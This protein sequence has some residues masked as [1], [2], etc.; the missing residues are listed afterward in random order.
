M[1]RYKQYYLYVKKNIKFIYA[2]LAIYFFSAIWGFFFPSFFK[3][4]IDNFITQILEITQNMN[5][6]QIFLFIL[7]NNIKTAFFAILFGAAFGIFPIF[8][9]FFNGYVLGYISSSVAK[10]SG[11]AQ[12]WKLLPHGVFELVAVFLSFSLGIKLGL[13]L[14]KKN[15]DKKWKKFWIKE[16]SMIL[17]IFVYVIIPLLLIAA[18]IESFFMFF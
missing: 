2:V 12:L 16:F 3:N 18:I 4:Y 15:K 7:Q 10:S 5:V 17:E 14:F 8:L 13:L 11:I 6:I 1:N 9:S